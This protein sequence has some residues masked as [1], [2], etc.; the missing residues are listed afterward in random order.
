MSTRAVIF[1]FNGTLSDDEP[2]L[3]RIYL[4][5]FAEYGR[6]ISESDYY[7]E[8]S[9]LAEHSIAA[10]CLGA[11]DPRIPAFIR[12]RIDRYKAAVAD[13]SA[14]P[15]SL[16][17]AV[18][19]AADRVPLAVVSGA[20][21]EEIVP[22]IAAAGLD[23]VL[24][25]VVA[26]DDVR[27]G[28]P[29]PESYLLALEALGVDGPR[30]AR[31]RG[32]GGRR[33]LR[34]GGRHAGDRRL[35]HAAPRAVREPRTRSW[36]RSTSS[37]C[38]RSS[39][40][41]RDRAPRGVVGATRRTRCAAFERA[42]ELGAD[43]VELDVHATADGSLVVCHDP[44]RGGEPRLEEALELLRGRIG[45]MCEL[46]SPWRYRRHDVVARV[47]RLLP[48]DAVVVCFEPRALQRGS[49]ACA[50]S[51]T[52]ASASRS[53]APRATRGRSASGNRAFGRR[54]IALARSPRAHDDGLHRQRRGDGCGSSPRSAST[55]SS[56]IVRSC[57]RRVLR[58]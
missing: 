2:L 12:E 49:P 32:H 53:V 55:G 10:A 20:A 9:G 3:C 29:H 48:D 26:D 17:A 33:R 23:D 45:I 34:Q 30:C 42:I 7:G 37:C 8:L 4:D 40:D 38:A 11:G 50:V 54:G 39:D 18:R 19:Y 22:A 27:F 52:S 43:F 31:V 15:G 58:G 21:R 56:A 25:L 6:P 13:S 36:T 41:L 28:K 14:I 5:L 46:K 16:R 57:L 47:E 44:P 35:R 24:G 1:D 51:S